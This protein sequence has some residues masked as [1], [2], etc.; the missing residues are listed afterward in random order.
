MATPTMAEIRG[1]AQAP[2]NIWWSIFYL[3]SGYFVWAA[4]RLGLSPNHL[5]ITAAITN[6]IGLIVIMVYPLGTASIVAA[7]CVFFLAHTLD[8]SD[9]QLA[10]VTNQRS[11]QGAWLDSSLDITKVA[12][13]TICY[14]TIINGLPLNSILVKAAGVFLMGNI[15]N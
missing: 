3:P 5:T 15:V 2:N 11:K 9:G 4:A 8:F 12:I 14:Y 6:V 13:V 7:Y 10:K 1:A